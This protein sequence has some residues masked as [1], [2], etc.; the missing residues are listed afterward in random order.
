VLFIT[1]LIFIVKG[2][3]PWRSAPCLSTSG[4]ASYQNL[5]Q[6]GI[7]PNNNPHQFS[8]NPTVPHYKTKAVNPLERH[9][10]ELSVSLVATFD[11]KWRWTA[12]F[13]LRPLYLRG[14]SPRHLLSRRLGGCWRPSEATNLLSL[15]RIEPWSLSAPNRL[16]IRRS[17][18]GK[19]WLLTLGVTRN[20]N[21]LCGGEENH[22]FL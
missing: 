20:I 8:D 7:H 12:L 4:W 6:C 10:S 17:K 9:K 11:S 21:T 1:E 15:L 2:T 19:E 16:R 5:R 22:T 18:R 3:L 14:K 13:T